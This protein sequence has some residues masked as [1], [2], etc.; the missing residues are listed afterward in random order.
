MHYRTHLSA[1]LGSGRC[2]LSLVF[3][4]NLLDLGNPYARSR[5]AD[6]NAGSCD[7]YAGAGNANAYAGPC[8]TNSNS[9]ANRFGWYLLAG[10]GFHHRL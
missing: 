4:G 5:N 7:T 10:L 9:R 3:S 8:D 1:W 6:A 2:A